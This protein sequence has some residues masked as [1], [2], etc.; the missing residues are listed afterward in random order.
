[1]TGAGHEGKTYELAGDASWTLGD[2]VKEISRQ[3]GK[4]IPYRNLPEAE[5]AKVLEGFGIPKPVAGAIASWD[6]GASKGGLFDESRQLSKLIGH[7]TTPM[8][9]T[10]REALRAQKG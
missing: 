7:P 2:L 4:S 10:V 8:P 6:T 1:M 3:T 9:E 5:Y